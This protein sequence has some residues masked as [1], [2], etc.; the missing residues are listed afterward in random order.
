MSTSSSS[1][2]QQEIPTGKK[3]VKYD[4]TKDENWNRIIP[5][6]QMLTLNPRNKNDLYE[7]LE[8]TR[9]LDHNNSSSTSN[10]YEFNFKEF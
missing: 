6:N 1:T 9:M 7:T 3:R 10:T 5:N 4:L 2:K 8:C